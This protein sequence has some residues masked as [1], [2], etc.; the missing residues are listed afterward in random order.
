MDAFIS[1]HSTWQF[2]DDELILIYFSV[3]DTIR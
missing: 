2:N 3:Y 1:L